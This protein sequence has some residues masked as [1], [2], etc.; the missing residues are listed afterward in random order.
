MI[1]GLAVPNDEA[2]KQIHT[3]H[4][5]RMLNE[6]EQ[7]SSI[8]ARE[9]RRQDQ[10]SE[11]RSDAFAELMEVVKGIR[12][13]DKAANDRLIELQEKRLGVMKTLLETILAKH[14]IYDSP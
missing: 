2:F 12:D 3:L 5:Q 14:N 6:V 7:L 13:D 10:Q 11:A 8:L 1:I 9:T 4:D